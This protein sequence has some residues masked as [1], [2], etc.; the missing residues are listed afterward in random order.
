MTS[1]E[2]TYDTGVHES[3]A[4]LPSPPKH[5]SYS[6]L[7]EIETCPRRYALGHASYPELWDGLGY[8]QFPHPRALFGD[9]VHDSLE[10]IIK[11]LVAA[12]CDSSGS[13]EAVS[14]LR[15][16]GGYSAVAADALEARMAKLDGNPRID[17]ERRERIHQQLED[18]IPEAR[19]EIQGYLQRMSL[20]PK[21]GTGSADSGKRAGTCRPLSIGTHPEVS[22]RVDGLRVKGRVD[23]M[24][25]TAEQVHIVDHKTG[26]E[27][28]SHLDQ[29]RFYA[30]LWDQ[31]KAV[32]DAGKRIGKLT[33]SYPANE[34]TIPTPSAAEL[35]A[36]VETTKTRVAEADARA[37]T[38]PPA[39]VTGDHCHLCPVRSICDTYWRYI[40]PGGKNSAVSTWFDFEGVVGQQNGIKSWWMLHPATQ[41]PVLL[42]RTTSPQQHLV[43]GER[44]RLLGIRRDEDPEVDAVVATLTTNS[45]IFVVAD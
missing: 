14:V 11:A 4:V 24:T 13:A 31:D 44:V 28:P 32:N 36:L 9:I 1:H 8:P 45:E 20:V 38:D 25:V 3:I 39:A 16:L 30:L 5:W 29:L 19:T 18:Q 22:L 27:D 41:K 26:A 23:L 15:D 10:R 12:G 43:Y 34:V 7:R 21:V 6:T 33:A 42:L 40:A 2:R 17:R 35:K 37:M